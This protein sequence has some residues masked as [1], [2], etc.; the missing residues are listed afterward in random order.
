MGFERVGR[1][2][3]RMV[4]LQ[5]APET[6]RLSDGMG[7]LARYIS[8]KS[9]G[10]GEVISALCE[11]LTQRGIECHLAT[12]NLRRRF[13][14]ENGL[15]DEQWVRISGTVDPDRIHLV[16]SALFDD[17]PDAYAG[18][19]LRTAAE[20][21]KTVVNQIIPR[22]RARNGGRLLIHSH[23]WMAGGIVTAYARR[24]GCPG[25]PGHGRRR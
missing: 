23:D 15:N 21:Q 11:G 25:W 12:L 13:Q 17:L 1:G 8:G 4:V 9:G 7:P 18:D 10:L 20:F 16:N 3:G 14:R 6:G 24:Q 22:I 5:I 19:C 2:Q